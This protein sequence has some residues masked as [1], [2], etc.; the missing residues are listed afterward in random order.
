MPISISYPG[1]YVEEVPGGGHTIRGV[2]TS[3]ALFAGWA[4]CGPVDRT[5]HVA[6]FADYERHYGGLDARSLLGYAVKQFFENGG[7]DAVVL[8]VAPGA[9]GIACDATDPSFRAALLAAFGPGTIT[10]RIDLF[11]LVCV[12]GLSDA[13]TIAALQ[14]HCRDRRAFLIVD[15]DHGSTAAD[16]VASLAGKT[17]PDAMN[18][19]IFFP[20]LRAP[21][22][23]QQGALR[24][25]PPCGYVAGV[26]ARTDVAHGVWKAPAG[27]TAVVNGAAGPRIAVSDAQSGE[28]N[29]RAVNCLRSFPGRDTVVWGA[30]TLDGAN[31]Q[32][33]QWKYVPVR[34]LALHIEESIARGTRWVVF[35]PNGEPL[36]AQ[37]RLVVGAFLHRLFLQGALLGSS[38]RQAYFVRCDGTTMTQAD[39]DNG[40]VNIVVGFAPLRPAE[41]VIVQLQQIVAAGRTPSST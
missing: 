30:R 13:A 17:G 7:V 35:E 36:W 31:D 8:R 6:S 25:F 19:A 32:G 33:S 2:A 12:P 18:S 22:P 15:C 27:G 24:D 38:P 21:D 37:V 26:F 29:T 41:F 10:D 40:L 11:N 4:A 3:I 20:W 5:E 23:M 9:D 16:V 14:K 28:L 34:R 1:V 39:I